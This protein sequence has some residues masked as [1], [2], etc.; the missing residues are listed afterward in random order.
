M[1]HSRLSLGELHQILL[2][3]VATS[4]MRHDL[5]NKLG[6]LRNATFFLKRKLEGQSIWRDDVRVPRFIQIMESELSAA[7]E[8]MTAG[9]TETLGEPRAEPVDAAAVVRAAV[10]M[11]APPA[12]VALVSEVAAGQHE[13]WAIGDEL[14]IAVRCLIDNAVEAILA[15]GPSG[16]VAVRCLP[17]RHGF[18]VIEV[19]DDGPG[20]ER[21]DPTP[22]L[23]PFASTRPGHLGLG[24]NVVRRVAARAGGS[25]ELTTPGNGVRAAISVPTRR[26]ETEGAGD[27][28][29]HPAGG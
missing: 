25:L 17:A 19:A 27:Q 12:G 13:V 6:S 5:R 23:A 1:T 4:G 18:A 11:R 10:E 21:N 24:L 26:A 28:S 8:I 2:V 14:S 16:A 7:D 29:T 9:M 3:T 15:A 22:W 20:F